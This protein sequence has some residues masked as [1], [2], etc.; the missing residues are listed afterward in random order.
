MLLINHYILI[1]LPLPGTRK[2]HNIVP[3]H[4]NAKTKLTLPPCVPDLDGDVAQRPTHPL[5]APAAFHDA[6]PSDACLISRRATYH[7]SLVFGLELDLWNLKTTTILHACTYDGPADFYLYS[8][9]ST[10]HLKIST[11]ME[12][13]RR[14]LHRN[15]RRKINSLLLL[16]AL[17]A[18]VL[19]H[20][21]VLG[22]DG[23]E[24]VGR[25]GVIQV[26]LDG[27]HV[28]A[29]LIVRMVFAGAVFHSAAPREKSSSKMI[30]LEKNG[31]I[32]V[33]PP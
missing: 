26:V 31:K 33:P 25:V 2:F 7:G 1:L 17:D 22:F 12:K 28:L 13:L 20:L 32:P 14:N 27:Q 8:K 18:A 11:T 19:L 3:F 29:M 5:P 24:L 30:I 10:K 9:T 4:K 15:L 6:Y 23:Q 21:P 16:F